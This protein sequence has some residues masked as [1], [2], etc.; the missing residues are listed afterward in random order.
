MPDT[1]LD[2]AEAARNTLSAAQALTRAARRLVTT[3][4]LLENA[5]VSLARGLVLDRVPDGHDLLTRYGAA[6][7]ALAGCNSAALGLEEGV[8]ALHFPFADEPE[9]DARLRERAMD[10]L[11]AHLAERRGR[12][13]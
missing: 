13:D 2:R 4:D 6:L 3:S 1:T 11:R 5:A 8:G 10:E 7:E 9:P 12:R